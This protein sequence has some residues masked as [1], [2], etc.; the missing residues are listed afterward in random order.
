MNLVFLLEEPSTKDL[1]M[2]LLPKLLP[3]GVVVYYL[4]FF[5]WN[6]RPKPFS[7]P[8][9]ACSKRKSGLAKRESRLPQG[10]TGLGPQSAGPRQGFVCAE[11]RR[12]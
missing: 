4:V 5:A 3:S 1:L 6:S 7:P 12:T 10:P 11:Q 9:V 8:K 2:G